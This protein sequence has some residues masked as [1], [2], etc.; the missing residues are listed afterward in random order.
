MTR[1]EQAQAY[2]LE[3]YNCSQAVALAF[4]DLLDI[5]KETLLAAVQPLGGGLARLRETCGTVSAAAVVLGLR[6]PEKSK[7]EIYSLVREFA[8]HFRAENGSINCGELLTGA[9]VRAEK[10][11]EPE[12]RTPEYY[13]KRPCPA[14]VFS[15]A[16]ILEELLG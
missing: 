1:A 13:K 8:E 15:S 10:G 9:G 6:F 7:A 11:G 16:Q 4:L 14:L 2:F 12:Q 3:G 5:P